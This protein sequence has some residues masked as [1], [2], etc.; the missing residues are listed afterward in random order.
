MLL[1]TRNLVGRSRAADLVIGDGTVSAE[2]ATVW[3][4][5]ARWR[6]RDLA[7][8]NGTLVDGERTL[9]GEDV[10]LDLG[11]RVAFGAE[12]NTWEV[13]DVLPPRPF[14]RELD[15]DARVEAVGHILFLPDE[16]NP[17]LTVYPD[18]HGRWF[19]E[20]DDHAGRV[21]D[22]A[23][24][25][26]GH[27]V[28]RLHLPE[29]LGRTVPHHSGVALPRMA[30]EFEVSRDQ[31]H[32]QLTGIVGGRRLDLR[33]RAHNYLLYVLAVRRLRDQGEPD[34]PEEEHGWVHLDE[35]SRLCG[36]DERRINLDVFR[37]RKHLACAGIDFAAS[38]VERRSG[39]RQLRIGVGRL[40]VKGED[41]D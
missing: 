40:L 14:A 10:A 12:K 16:D 15:T 4:D 29:P 27:T 6:V 8:R 19:A 13:V 37:A 31:E 20:D 3:W 33:V 32:V 7:S 1:A 38:V 23:F 11:T 5:G 28:W 22:L 41:K 26:A 21:E 17:S 30:F 39:S 9:P 34:L 25:T 36:M 2:H 24:L 18:A 35:L